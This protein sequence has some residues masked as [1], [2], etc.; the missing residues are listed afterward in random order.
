MYTPPAFSISD[1]IEIREMIHTSGLATLVTMTSE[2]LKGTPLPLFLNEAEGPYGTVYGHM[3][4]ANPQWQL[5]P[6]GE[7]LVIFTG[8]DAYVS[9]G[10]Y[11][12]KAEHGKVVPTWNYS[13]V[14]AY[15]KAEFFEE[16]GRVRDV[17]S[18]LTDK[19]E[20]SRA[21]PWSVTDAPETFIAA[22]LRGI[23]GVRLEISRLDAKKKFSQNR[24]AADRAGVAKGLAE[25]ENTAARSMAGQI[26]L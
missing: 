14:H 19:H 17:V 18:R 26:P 12:S 8:V 25:E 3:A 2:G 15:G 4:R 10:W 16:P 22:Q 23:V 9:P 1:E 13:A 6:Q 11:A 24:P 20:R 21:A 5:E 7:A